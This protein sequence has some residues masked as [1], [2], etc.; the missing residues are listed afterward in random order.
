MSIRELLELQCQI[1]DELFHRFP[2]DDDVA[3]DQ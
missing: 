3:D 1:A 2:D